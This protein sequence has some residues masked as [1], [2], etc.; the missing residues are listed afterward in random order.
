MMQTTTI[1]PVRIS[2]QRST[3]LLSS[4]MIADRNPVVAV[5]LLLVDLDG[6]I[7]GRLVGWVALRDAEVRRI[8]GTTG[9]SRSLTSLVAFDRVGRVV[10]ADR[11][12]LIGTIDPAVLVTTDRATSIPRRVAVKVDG[13]PSIGFY[14]GNLPGDWS[15]IGTARTAD[16]YDG[17]RDRTRL[18]NLALIGV[19]LLAATVLIV[20]TQRADRTVRREQARFRAMVQNSGDVIV[21]LDGAGRMLYASPSTASLTG[22]G[23][24]PGTTIAM[25]YVHPDDRRAVFAVFCAAQ[26]APGVVQRA[27][28]RLSR[29]DGS[30]FWLD[31]SVTDLRSSPADGIV[32]NARDITD[33][34]RL[35]ER[36]HEQATI[37]ALT[38]LGN[39]RLL[40]N[41]LNAALAGD[42]YPA[43]LYIDL[44]R[45]K[46]VN[47]QLG[48]EAGDELL[49]LVAAR[50]GHCLRPG[51]T[52]A[53]VGGDEFVI[54]APGT[55]AANADRLA[56]R[57]VAVIEQPFALP[58]DPAVRIG[59][60][61]GIDVARS[62]DLPDDVLRRADAA[63]YRMKQRL[64]VTR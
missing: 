6:Q 43:V 48:H 3:G 50:V 36:L 29:A 61:I 5:G 42:R 47:D 52:L 26:A 49:R 56:A 12:E 25:D 28:F 55:T 53:R 60:S 44:D 17:V 20:I 32:I 39:R 14:V 10:T 22:H 9:A 11:R 33:N 21:V 46:P 35:R 64:T 7:R 34:R 41:H 13:A 45:F 2:G 62:S 38:G 18:V 40:Y 15:V 4:V 27:E 1:P 30:E 37:D 54:V 63:M 19:I 57:V 23:G 59:A 16:F 51:D 31:A 8:L 24:E 58:G